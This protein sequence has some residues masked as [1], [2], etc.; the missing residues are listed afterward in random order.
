MVETSRS[1]RSSADDFIIKLGASGWAPR[2]RA[3]PGDPSPGAFR[4]G[5]AKSRKEPALS[6]VGA[7]PE[8]AQCSA[9][10]PGA[11]RVWLRW[12]LLAAL[13]PPANQVATAPRA[14]LPYGAATQ[15]SRR[16]KA[17]LRSTCQRF[18]ALSRRED[19]SSE[20]AEF[21]GG[22]KVNHVRTQ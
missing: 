7:G 4:A 1:A 9:L 11:R 21:G 20:R 14:L 19:A 10:W 12:Q 13:A 22:R 18:A 17:P 6:R 16:I 8:P 5:A 3:E 2:L 15:A